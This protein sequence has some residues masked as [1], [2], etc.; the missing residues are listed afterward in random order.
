M[1]QVVTVR[2]TVKEGEED[3]VLDALRELVAASRAE[4]GCLMYQ[5]HRDPENARVLYLYE[6]YRDADAYR[7]HA[8][9]EHFQRLALGEIFPRL[10]SRERGSYETVEL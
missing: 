4:A 2:W 5:L 3:A 10:E 7:A 8:D 6:Q 9:S 1:A